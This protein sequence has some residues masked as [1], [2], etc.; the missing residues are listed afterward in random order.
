MPTKS[1]VGTGWCTSSPPQPGTVS[2][3]SLSQH[4]RVGSKTGKALLSAR[5]SKIAQHSQLKAGMSV[6]SLLSNRLDFEQALQRQIPFPPG[7][8]QLWGNTLDFCIVISLAM[9]SQHQRLEV[10]ILISGQQSC[11][12]RR[13]IFFSLLF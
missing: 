10:H 2:Q 1:C 8:S 9:L 7:Q 3:A 13:K 6:K 12:G 5:S 4:K 11:F